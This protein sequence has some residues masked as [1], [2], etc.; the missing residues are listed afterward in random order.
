MWWCRVRELKGTIGDFWRRE[1]ETRKKAIPGGSGLKVRQTSEER[2]RERAPRLSRYASIVW[3]FLIAATGPNS[4]EV[5]GGFW[6]R[7]RWVVPGKAREMSIHF[8]RP[9]G[10]QGVTTTPAAPPGHGD[11]H[12]SGSRR[13]EGRLGPQ[14]PSRASAGTFRSYRVL[15]KG[16][17][18]QQNPPPQRLQQ[19]RHTPLPLPCYPVFAA[20][21]RQCSSC[22]CLLNSPPSLPPSQGL[23]RLRRRGLGQTVADSSR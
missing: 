3:L 14:E 19:L 22:V 16:V 9:L 23:R 6:G 15:T 1:R 12:G 8:S 17:T 21:L 7:S 2:P 13:S 5:T 10:R 4:F 20:A 11:F 18:V